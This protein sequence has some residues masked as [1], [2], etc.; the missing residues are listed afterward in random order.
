M[1]LT[2]EQD[3]DINSFAKAFVEARRE[4]RAIQS[5]TLDY[6]RRSRKV[7]DAFRQKI[8]DKVFAI[9][10]VDPAII[11]ER[12]VAND[13]ADQKF[14]ES[15][16]LRINSNSAVI[17][18]QQQTRIDA[19]HR[20]VPRPRRRTK[21]AFLAGALLTLADKIVVLE[22]GF[23][24]TKGRDDVLFSTSTAEQK[25]IIRFFM[26]HTTQGTTWDFVAYF[27]WTAPAT[28]NLDILALVG[29]NGSNMWASQ[30][31]CIEAQ[32]DQ[33]VITYLQITVNGVIDPNCDA[34]TILYK[35][36]EH[37]PGCSTDM[38][39][40]VVNKA[41]DLEMQYPVNAGDNVIV[42][43]W[44]EAM[45]Q[46]DEAHGEI[47]FYNAAKQINVPGLVLTVSES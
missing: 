35:S 25:N 24:V 15:M 1:A 7:G 44:I 5:E 46:T 47:D 12:Q 17:G 9:S 34:E 16:K 10:G 18:R 31:G 28:G 20:L 36:W 14:L 30:H 39:M 6:A 19:F 26:P 38:G 41:V 13:K 33:A 42:G 45:L 32:V 8:I 2:P 27:S 21:G 3:A 4:T 40:N 11:K 37:F 43:V 22:S 23:V 29:A